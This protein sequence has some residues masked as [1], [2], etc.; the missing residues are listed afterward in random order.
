MRR[1]GTEHQFWME[2]ERQDTVLYPERSGEHPFGLEMNKPSVVAPQPV[3][4][5]PEHEGKVS[6]GDTAGEEGAAEG[7][8]RRITAPAEF[9]TQRRLRPAYTSDSLAKGHHP[10]YNISRSFI[11]PEPIL[12]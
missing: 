5:S 11:H 3:S 8:V 9:G 2:T 1:A 6:T 12:S 7:V 10:A 4:L